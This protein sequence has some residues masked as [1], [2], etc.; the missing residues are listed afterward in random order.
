MASDARFLSDVTE[1]VG[2]R[3]IPVMETPEGELVQDTTA[4][5]DLVRIPRNRAPLHATRSRPEVR[6]ASRRCIRVELYDAIGDALPM[7]LS[8]KAGVILAH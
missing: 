3:V 7:V 4:I 2:H 5:I 6:S 1:R 8:R